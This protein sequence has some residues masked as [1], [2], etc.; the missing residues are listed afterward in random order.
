[1]DLARATELM[2]WVATFDEE[3][4]ALARSNLQKWINSYPDEHADELVSR[5]YSGES[6]NVTSAIAELYLHWKLIAA[7]H[8]VVVHPELPGS[9]KRVGIHSRSP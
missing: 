7:A 9:T 3:A 2:R 8:E 1:M 6:D 5:L 4:A